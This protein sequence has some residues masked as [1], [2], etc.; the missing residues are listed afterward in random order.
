MSRVREYDQWLGAVT[1]AQRNLWPTKELTVGDHLFNIDIQCWQVWN[2]FMWISIC[3]GGGGGG[4]RGE[5]E[6]IVGNA[7]AGDTLAD[8]DFLDPGNGAGIAAAFA[9]A[10]AGGAHIYIRRGSYGPYTSILN[11]PP[12]V[13]V[14]GSGYGTFIRAP[15]NNPAFAMTGSNSRV[16]SMRIEGVRV[17]SGL[18]FASVE[19]CDIDGSNVD[20]IQVRSGCARIIIHKNTI[21]N[22]ALGGIDIQQ[23]DFCSIKTNYIV[24]N[25]SYGLRLRAD[26]NM[27][28]IEDATIRNNG[29][30]GVI[31]ASAAEDHNIV[32]DCILQG[33]VV[34]Q[35]SDA[36]TTTEKIHLDI[37]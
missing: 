26:S 20:G 36:S 4:K 23:S 17:N 21:Q 6:I 30:N 1:T 11:I 16:R 33:N 18:R 8:C 19:D 22:S 34:P 27:N 2:G 15:A 7:P 13:D 29:A 9:A 25:A 5:A 28:T 31:I 32:V 3:P 35:F 37:L 12:N 24:N 14:Q 10:P